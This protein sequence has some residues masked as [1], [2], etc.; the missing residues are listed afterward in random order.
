MLF[1]RGISILLR[2][3]VQALFCISLFLFNCA[4]PGLSQ[5]TQP[6]GNNL[7]KYDD[8]HTET[9]TKKAAQYGIREPA[10]DCIGKRA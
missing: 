9:K 5:K 8:P 1:S 2:K 10:T 6:E 7:P 4:T 3:A